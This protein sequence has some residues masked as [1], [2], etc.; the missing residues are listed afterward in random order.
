MS[1]AVNI[2]PFLQSLADDV[3]RI[4]VS[5]STVGECL[6]ELVKRYPQLKARLFT[7]VGKMHKG[8]NIFIN[9]ESAYP[10]VL[11]RPVEDGDIIHIAHPIFGG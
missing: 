9:G 2:P 11:A 3:K 4:D 6:D 8:F 10:D 1:I 7:G 5:G